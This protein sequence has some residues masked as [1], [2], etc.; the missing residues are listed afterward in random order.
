MS[1]RLTL[2]V[3]DDVYQ[4]LLQAAAHAGQTP[5]QWALGLLRARATTA[6]QR[7]AALAR[8]LRHAGAADLGRATGA[9]NEGIEADL[10]REYGS[11]HESGA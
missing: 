1:H 6:E 3:P 4:A 2:E 7:A 9:A 11:A 8:L 10:A 5:E